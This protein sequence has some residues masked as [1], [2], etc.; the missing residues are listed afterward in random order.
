MTKPI[1][2][3][4]SRFTLTNNGNDY[5]ISVYQSIGDHDPN[6][7]PIVFITD[8]DYFFGTAAELV[9]MQ[10]LSQVLK[11]A[12]L[13][14][15]G[16]GTD[17]LG[18]RSLRFRDLS[19]PLSDEAREDLP[20][21]KDMIG[22]EV[23]GAADFLEFIVGNVTDEIARRYP[24]ANPARRNL[25]G[26]SLGGLLAT[27]ALFTQPE[28]FE[29]FAIGSPGLFWN[30]YAVLKYSHVL[31]QKLPTLERKPR[32]FIGVGGT[33]EDVPDELPANYPVTIEQL[34][35]SMEYTRMIGSARDLA[36]SL[37]DMG[38]PEVEIRIFE[39][40]GHQQVVP[41]QLNCGLRFVLR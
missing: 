10:T 38:L 19:L 15:I 18:T 35:H 23:G 5:V 40:E 20:L 41:F 17:M 28:E 14:G 34:R 8:A 30:R 39:G 12:I 2:E 25:F 3:S 6:S 27:Y 7:L 21:L 32:V 33:E 11:P 29:G 37:T 9:G 16:Y 4:I 36:Q 1:I 31:A 26:T 24:V 22:P 13:V